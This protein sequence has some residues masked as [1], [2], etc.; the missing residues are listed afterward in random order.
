MLVDIKHV[1]PTFLNS[2]HRLAQALVSLVDEADATLLSYHCYSLL[3]RLSCVGLLLK[4][5]IALHT[6]PQE[7]ALIMDLFT[8]GAKDLLPLLPTIQNL[9]AIPSV[10]LQ[11]ETSLE[12]SLEPKMLW[13]HKRRGFRE[14]F[15][16][17]YDRNDH[18]LDQDMG[19]DLFRRHFLD[20]KEPLIS[21]ET[22]YQHVDIVNI[23]DPRWRSLAS[24]ERS[25]SGD[26]SYE[27]LYP[28]SF[29]P[30][31]WLYLDGTSQSSFFGEAEYHEALVHPAMIAHPNPK[32]VAIIGGGE[33]A[34]LREVLKHKTLEK[35]MMVEIDEELVDICREHLPEWSDCTDIEGSNA[36]SCFDDSR[37]SVVF[38]DAF[39]WFMDVFGREGVDG[40]YENEEE[41]FD[42]IIMDA[43]DPEKMVEI[44][45]N[46]YEDNHFVNSLY[47]G[48]S[49]DG[50]FVVQLGESASNSDPA[51]ETG[52]SKDKSVLMNALENVG[53]KSMHI[54]DESH[55]HY[56]APWNILAAFKNYKTNARWYRPVA[57]IEI[58]LHRRLHRTRSGN[59][60]LRYFDGPTMVDFQVPSRAEEVTYC[61]KEVTPW[62]CGIDPEVVNHHY[63]YQQETWKRANDDFNLDRA[64]TLYAEKIHLFPSSWSVMND[65]N[66]Q[67]NAKDELSSI[68]TFA[69]EY[70]HPSMLMGKKSVDVGVSSFCSGRNDTGGNVMD[71]AEPI[72]YSPIVDR[73]LLQCL[74]CAGDMDRAGDFSVKRE[75]HEYVQESY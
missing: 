27:S 7:G 73:H 14:G 38:E 75:G 67:T 57:G 4:S 48:L 22:D 8:C 31:R 20:M 29:K 2:E 9:F 62:E 59:P 37:A 5:H 63:D 72:V 3:P 30:D 6:W 1:D 74:E 24:Y 18:P 45:G 66:N 19:L 56:D 12:V 28:E 65:I 43:L 16:P 25:L 26:G 13:S 71:F 32:R 10:D 53:F 50:L 34:T 52:R 46:L 44:A 58:E 68:V 49:E 39:K 54:Y 35:V 41:P 64:Q 69:E 36:D 11:G 21:E 15:D 40:K 70:G 55:S 33:G 51:P 23:I 61:R 42:V 47:K 60:A 17:D